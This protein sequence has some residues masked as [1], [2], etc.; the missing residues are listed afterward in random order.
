M[1]DGRNLSNPLLTKAPFFRQDRANFV[2]YA[3]RIT[4][5]LMEYALSFLSYQDVVVS[6]W[7]KT[8]SAS[9]FLS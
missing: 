2:F 1:A 8:L 3:E 7:M 9:G 5:L 6:G 4:R